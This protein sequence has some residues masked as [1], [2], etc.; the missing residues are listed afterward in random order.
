MIVDR[1][2]TK[3]SGPVCR[4]CL[5]S[6]NQVDFRVS[7]VQQHN[8][9]SQQCTWGGENTKKLPPST[10]QYIESLKN[11]IRIL[12]AYVQRC[13]QEHGGLG[14]D[15]ASDLNLQQEQFGDNNEMLG[16]EDNEGDDS[17]A[18]VVSFSGAAWYM[19]SLSTQPV[20]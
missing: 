17:R 7:M 9:Y 5:D 8:S 19:F 14:D 20:S 4:S 13:R 10:R 1:R 6:G 11:R 2:K 16:T 18:L 15:P 3:C 12:E